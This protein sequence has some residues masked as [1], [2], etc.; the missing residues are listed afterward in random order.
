MAPMSSLCAV[1]VFAA[2]GDVA[3]SSAAGK[4][5]DGARSGC[6]PD[7]EDEVCLLARSRVPDDTRHASN[8]WCSWKSRFIVTRLWTVLDP[9]NFSSQQVVDEFRNDFAPIVTNL[10]GFLAYLGTPLKNKKRAFFA[11][12][13]EDQDTAAAA[14]HAAVKFVQEGVLNDKIERFLFTEGQIAFQIVHP[15]LC[16]GWFPPALKGKGI[17]VQ[18]W[19]RQQVSPLSTRRIVEVIQAGFGQVVRGYPGFKMYVGSVVEDSGKE[20]VF[21]LSIF[22]DQKEAQF[23]SFQATKFVYGRGEWAGSPF[24]QSLKGAV[25]F[26]NQETGDFDFGFLEKSK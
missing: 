24:A 2:L 16:S 5:D 1:L 9:K 14:Q 21:L 3:F 15:L 25:K 18:T 23:A 13:F 4:L 6:A 20:L 22:D 26:V 11:N 12:V 10:T 17:S 7:A 19:E 8:V